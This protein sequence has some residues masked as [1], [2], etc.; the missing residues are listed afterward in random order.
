MPNNISGFLK[1]FMEMRKALHKSAPQPIVS[2]LANPATGAKKQTRASKG[3]S[4]ATLGDLHE[5]TVAKIIE[6]KPSKKDV[7]AYFQKVCDKLT[8]EKMK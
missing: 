3:T 7:K 4:D 5:M 1:D 8:A 6:T 2:G